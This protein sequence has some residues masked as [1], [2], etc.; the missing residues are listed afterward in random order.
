MEK[1][2]S[3]TLGKTVQQISIR[4]ARKLYEKNV[5][6]FLTA[7]NMRF[8]N[9]WTRPMP[10]QKSRRYERDTFDGICSEFR[11]YNCD[12]LRGKYIRFYVA[13]KDLK[14]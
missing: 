1:F 3:E 12:N 14:N 11:Y 5:E 8:D 10:L 13:E 6:L 4:K 9:S 7:S 2:Y